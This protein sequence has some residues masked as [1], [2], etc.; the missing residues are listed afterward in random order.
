MKKLLSVL[1]VAVML[2]SMLASCSGNNNGE[3]PTTTGDPGEQPA[4]EVYT[5]PSTETLKIMSFNL[6]SNLGQNGTG[7]PSE[8]GYN[9]ALAARAE[10]LQ[11]NPDLL[12]IQEDS[13]KWIELLDL[14]GYT[15]YFNAD[16]TSGEKTAIYVR[17]G[18]D[19]VASGTRFLTE[20]NVGTGAAL[21]IKDLTDPNSVYK[22]KDSDLAFLKITPN[23]AETE[24]TENRTINKTSGNLLG[25]RKMT[26]V[27]L[28]VN[29]QY[30]IYVNTHLQNRSQNSAFN[31]YVDDTAAKKHDSP[32][33]RI[34]SLERKKSIDILQ[35]IIE[36]IKAVYP[37][38]H[39][40]ITG[41]MND[42]DYHVDPYQ[43][44]TKMY[45]AFLSYQ[46][47]DTNK[48]AGSE[49][50]TGNDGSWNNNFDVNKQGS[51]YPNEKTL[52]SGYLD[53]CFISSGLTAN[54]FTVGKGYATFTDRKGNEKTY[55]TSDHLPVMATVSF[56]TPG[57][58]VVE[59]D[60]TTS[61]WTGGTDIRWYTGDKSEYTLNTAEEFSGFLWLRR[62]NITDFS[63]VTVKLGKNMDF[64]SDKNIYAIPMATLGR[65]GELPFKGSLNGM[66]FTLSNIRLD[67]AVNGA[68]LL[69]TLG[70]PSVIIR[71]LTVKNIR[72]RLNYA[73]KTSFGAI[74]GTIEPNTTVIMGNVNVEMSFEEGKDISAASIGGLIGSLNT[75]TQ[76]TSRVTLQ[77]CNVVANITTN[78]TKVGGL[79]GE[80]SSEV[81]LTIKNCTVS[82]KLSGND[83]V[84]GLIGY[85]VGTVTP[86]NC[87][88]TA[89]ITA[90]GSHKGDGVVNK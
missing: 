36:E 11:M 55:Y 79:V 84:G 4:P 67:A 17:D 63:G 3:N 76:Y 31:G 6:Q 32:V 58:L 85:A 41:D 81:E 1:L 45:Q 49:N 23:S 18:L 12:G 54:H 73:G 70:G 25:N 2:L 29:G 61:Y 34:R 59:E 8:E 62:N 48:E 80:Y 77:N 5:D 78:G 21:T 13:S 64:A 72:I 88:V 16:I 40:A 60:P 53:Y 10:I 82:G 74:A 56:S 15:P 26:Y 42:N 9:R 30:L 71:D 51:D 65:T 86:E 87:T 66:G 39:V 75:A 14:S 33:Q 27:V 7:I 46:Y 47:K 37:G 89:E 83:Y 52:K 43:G 90:K 28:N 57:K 38:A 69:G 24:L 22:M 20:N 68:G 19:V 50:H 44:Y 35:S